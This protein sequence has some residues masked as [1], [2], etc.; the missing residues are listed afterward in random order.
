MNIIIVHHL[1][2]VFQCKDPYREIFW[3]F[4]WW[5]F[6][7]IHSYFSVVLVH[8]PISFFGQIREVKNYLDFF[9]DSWICSAIEHAN[10]WVIKLI[11]EIL[12]AEP[13]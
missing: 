2:N 10:H 13:S 6:T 3:Q 9:I 5:Q 12:E 4:V 11:N 7:S 1:P 8:M